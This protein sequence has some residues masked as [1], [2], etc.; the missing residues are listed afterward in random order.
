MIAGDICI[1]ETAITTPEETALAAA[2]RMQEFNVGCLVVVEHRDEGNKPVGII[3][4]R[5]LALNVTA[6]DGQ[7]SVIAVG[8]VMSSSLFTVK[9]TEKIYDILQKMRYHGIR[10]VPVVNHIGLLI[11][12]LTA[13]D[14]LE[15]L[16][17][18][19]SQII[20]VIQKEQPSI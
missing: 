19:I 3:T 5:D 9:E 20:G 14:I 13:D 15:V 4:D 8:N 10:R 16:H 18:Q 12:I 11:G 1:R 6:Q 17:R 7:P 2:Q